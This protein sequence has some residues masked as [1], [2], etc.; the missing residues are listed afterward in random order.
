M[1]PKIRRL[2][3]VS[4]VCALRPAGIRVQTGRRWRAWLA[5]ACLVCGTTSNADGR[6]VDEDVAEADAKALDAGRITRENFDRRHVGGPDAEAGIDDWFLGNG[7]LCAAVSDP[8]HES[9]LTPTGGVLI[10]L[11]HCGAN[12]D[13]WAVLQSVLN[14]DQNEAVPIT[15]VDAGI[16]DGRAWVRTGATFSGIELETTYALDRVDPHVLTVST[17]ARRIAPGERFFSLGQILLHPSRQTPVFSLRTDALDHSTGF[18]YREV[19]RSS[20][21]SLLSSLA[22][23]DLSIL[24]AGPGNPPISYGV[25]RR[26]ATLLES[27]TTA[28]L[29]SFRVSGEH[30]TF[31]NTLTEPVLLGSPDAPPGLLQLAQLPFM[32]VR[33]NRELAT[34]YRIHVGRRADVA[35]ITDRIWPDATRVSGRVDDPSIRI[36]VDRRSGAPIS[37]VRPDDKG[38]FSLRLPE[39]AYR[40]R[41]LAPGDRH[42]SFDFDVPPA[43]PSLRLPPLSVGPPA[44][45][46]LPRRFVGRLIFLRADGTGPAVFG[47]NLL[48]IDR[49]PSTTL[50]G[51]EA[52]FLNLANSPLD[53]EQVAL[54]PGTYR[55]LAVRGPEY[56]S[57]EVEIALRAG[58]TTRLEIAPLERVAP[59][60]GW[61]AADLHVHTG[62]SF[63]SSLPAA[64]QAIAFAASGAELLFATEH[65]RIVDP[66]EAIRLAGVEALV[67]SVT[68]VELTS[69]YRGGDA[70]FATG[71][72]NAFPMQPEPRS[73]RAGAPDVE[74]RR[75]RTLL[76]DLRKRSPAPFVQLN[77]PRPELEPGAADLFFEHMGVVGEPF[78]PTRPLSLPPNAA[79]SEPDPVHGVRDLDFHGLEV[80]NSPSLLRYRRVRAD[81]LSLLLQGERHV[82]TASSDSH[83]LGVLV[84]L[85]RT[86]LR[87]PSETDPSHVGARRDPNAVIASLRAGHAWGTTGPLLDIRLEDAGIGDLHAGKTGTLEIAVDAAE[88]I[89]VAEWRAYV[90][91]ELVHRAPIARGER[92]ALPLVFAADAFVTV[93]V[94][95]PAT[96]RYAEALPGFVPFAF[97]NPI[98]VDADANGRFEAPGLPDALP[99][100]IARP[101]RPD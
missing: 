1:L 10:D 84:G 40:A 59:T 13:Q 74:G 78:D 97:S 63:D 52:P 15:R 11:G 62:S 31:V 21:R 8:A 64:H 18:A 48:E 12:D 2:H 3:N 17:R 33:E 79:L 94:E 5:L 53:P 37:E 27:D 4:I 58:Q 42:R 88:W 76:A 44:R 91:G 39:G 85:P 49:A 7:V 96:G 19:D 70:P 26:S 9:P 81:W 20:T 54:A 34:E 43:A 65:D 51:L 90:N 32:D 95:G 92:D 6:A 71:H 57:R 29:S 68:G 86:Y 72:L 69:S 41:L 56:A 45:I 14:L 75:L 47:A 28:R 61:L 87:E 25:E 89:P 82:A 73:Y 100:T 60:P 50:G 98:F 30:F 67:R 83:R 55:V 35:S 93:E 80:L 66:R 16:D 38:D 77:H 22:A 101:D 36:Q 24:V 99:P 23:S 46:R